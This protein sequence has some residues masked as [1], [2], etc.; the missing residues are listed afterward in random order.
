MNPTVLAM[1]R[2]ITTLMLVVAL[3]AGGVLAYNRMRVDIF[4]SL[5]VPKIYVFLDFIGMSPDQMEGFIVN[6]LELYFQ[7]VDG[8]QDIDTRNIQQ[9]ALCELSFFPGTDMGQAMAQVVA[10]SDRAMS[11][12]PKGTLPPM[13]MRMDAGSVPV[14]YLVFESTETSLGAMG[15]LAQNIIRPLVQKNVPGTVA[16][17][18][19]GP[20]MRSIVVNVDPNKLLDYN[21]TPQQVIDALASGNTVIP[22][23]NVYIKDAMPMVANNATVGDIQ[24]LGSIPLRMERNVYLRDVATIQDYVDITYGYALVNGKNSVYLPIIKKDTGSTLTVVADIHKSM[25]LFQDAVPKDVKVDFEFDESPTVVAAVRSVA[26][27]GMIGAGLTGLMILL[28]LGDVRSVLVVV[29]NIPLALLGSL[30]GLWLTGNTINIMSLGGMALAIGILV[31]EATV[32]IENTHVQMAHTSNLATA[33][34]H[35]SN[36]TAVPR[37]LALLC[38]LSVFIPAFLMQDPLRSLFM[39]LTLAVGFAMISSYILSSTFVP[40]LC[41]TLLKHKEGH[42]EEK[43]G[44]F[45]RVLTVYS[46]TV[47][48]FVRLRFIVVPIYL[49]A[50]AL[51]L[52]VLGLQVGRELFPQ[53][54][55]GEFVL[56]FRPPPGSNF[57]LT[58]Q[59]AVKCLEEIEREA[60]RG[61]ITITM[62]YVGQVATN[63]GIDNMVLFMRGPDDGQ[64]RI[65]LTEDSGI[66]LDK[67]RERLRE[68]LPKNVI[69]WLAKRLEQG[70][71]SKLEAERQAKL[72]TFGFEPGDIVTSVMSF[73]SSTPIAVRIV[74]TDLR[75]VRQHADKIAANMRRIPFLRD[76]GYVQ[77]LDYPTVELEI[78]REKA[79]LSGAK[80]EDV[81]HAVVMATAS[82]RFA[83]LNYWI[84]S[85]TGFDY[86]VQIQVPPLRMEKPEDIETLPVQSVN[87]LVNL[88][89]RDVAK[90]RRGLRPGEIDRDMSQRYVTLTANVEGEDMGRASRQVD[91]ALAAAGEPPRGV[92]V[93]TMGQIPP[94]NEMFES[95]AFG[96]LV[97]VFVIFVLLTAYFQ[98][99]RLALISIGAVPGVLAGIA[100]MLYLTNTSLNIESF[101]GSIMC[102]GVSVSNSVMLV[103]FIDEHWKKGNS[104]TEAAIV[105]ASERLRPI[106]MTACAMTVGMVPMALALER[107]SQMQAP[108]G[109]AVIGGLVMSTFA[110]LLVVP[111]IF[112][113]VIGKKTAR[114]PSIYPNDPESS[115]YD[116]NVY[117]GEGH[118]GDAAPSGPPDPNADPNHVDPDKGDEPRDAPQKPV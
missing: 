53:I 77:Q 18:P 33:V 102:L 34:L 40:I 25:K 54:D 107:G 31:D 99:P 23:G 98:S 46:K 35:A 17:S 38:I 118:T 71:L 108:L 15:D 14:G 26:T 50:C 76:V 12:M 93:E 48:W 82:T 81:A 91:Q 88:M 59:M 61:H 86:L 92:R 39:P 84:D 100:T 5:N 72:S 4:P 52:G 58:R 101:M 19:F 113:I 11:W 6:E 109:R 104:S 68:V 16:I 7:Y 47:G 28:F 103:T 29:A 67:F 1:K 56:R 106:L 32:T 60:G 111:S 37:L 105:G 73:G 42:G 49:A 74:G 70:G 80:V 41:V 116:P 13:I 24:K 97:A 69:P 90:V 45:D 62:G 8:I 96:L 83:S 51:V 22:A 89:I 36:A 112:A 75:M 10:M 110:T 20:N 55:S 64:L 63:F 115:H 79:G 2:P 87:P 117:A 9:V 44:L 85:K 57:E 78:D 114:S 43:K 95:L 30:V 21:L 66:K 94:M 3:I 65:A 27:E